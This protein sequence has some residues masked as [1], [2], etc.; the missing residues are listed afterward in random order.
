VGPGRLGE[1]ASCVI[2]PN[3]HCLVDDPTIVA[4]MW[5]FESAACSS[6]IPA[7][8]GSLLAKAYSNELGVAIGPWRWV[9]Y[10][11]T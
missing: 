5:D 10:R 9:L 11:A 1:S 7:R 3:L 4:V 2:Q 8:R 6:A